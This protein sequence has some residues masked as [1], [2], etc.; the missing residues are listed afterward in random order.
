MGDYIISFPNLGLEMNPSRVAFSI[1]GKDI[2]WYG[3]LIAIGFLCGLIYAAKYCPKFKIKND[4]LIDCVLLAVPLAV[5]FGRLYY[6]IFNFSEY[7]GDFWSAFKVWEG[8][9]A[10]YGVIFGA[11]LAVFLMCRKKKIRALP[12]G[13]LAA[14]PLLFAQA[15]GRW[16]NF[17][18]REAFGVMG[19]G[20]PGFVRNILEFFTMVLKNGSSEFAVQPIFFYESV[21]NLIGVFILLWVTHHRKF[22]G[23]VLCTYMAW[24]GFARF[25]L[26][27]LRADSLKLFG[28]G[29]RVSGLISILIFLAGAGVIVYNLYI[30]KTPLRPARGTYSEEESQEEPAEEPIE[31]T[32]N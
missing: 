16:G 5:I 14:V 20:V 13:D 7:K 32:E 2:Y 28:T 29:I 11:V 3:V 6:V 24:Y 10:I 19:D 9:I 22:D 31:E 1:F 8:G 21:W 26:E 15:I 27:F 23:Q 12:I 25:F 4:D 18:N 17:L 30:R